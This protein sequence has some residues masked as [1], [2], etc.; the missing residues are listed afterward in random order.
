M[1]IGGLM[2]EK[3]KRQMFDDLENLT[4]RDYVKVTNDEPLTCAFTGEMERDWVKF[5]GQQF[6]RS[7]KKDSEASERF[8]FNVYV[9]ET[10][11]VSRLEAGVGLAR[12]IYEAK[13]SPNNVVEITRSGNGKSTR[14][15]IEHVETLD[16]D[17]CLE[18]SEL[19]RPDLS[20]LW[21]GQSLDKD[22]PF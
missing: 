1:I 19:D 11:E 9:P 8:A 20:K 17:R 14:F 15:K 13:L 4:K 6:V 10:N 16:E 5:T 22:I 3:R 7:T 12:T 2:N 18:I 21:G